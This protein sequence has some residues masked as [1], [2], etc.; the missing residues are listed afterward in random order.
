MKLLL[1]LFCVP[2][3]SYGQL[4]SWNKETLEIKSSTKPEK[5]EAS[6]EFKNTSKKTITF[7]KIKASCGCVVVDKPEKVEPGES[8]KITF[9]A[10]IPYAG[11]AYTKTISVDT[12]E[13]NKVEYKLSFKVT[14]TDPYVPRKPRTPSR[15]PQTKP[16][17][18]KPYTPPKGYSRPQKMTSRSLLVEKLMAKQTLARKKAY[19]PQEE[20]PFLPLPINKKL[21]HDY[22]G[23]RIYTCCEQCLVL[24]KESPH[25]AIIK[26]A[27]KTQTPILVKDLID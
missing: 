17:P 12:D 8:G 11:G 22:E 18:V 24:V 5:H 19:H 10:P 4:L 23:M 15:T 7:I 3:I 9:K 26:L 2:F 6:F 16:S 27:E 20:C 25:H 1:I 14:N 21:Y 13:S